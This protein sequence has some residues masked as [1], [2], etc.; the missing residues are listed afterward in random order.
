MY[1]WTFF[2]LM[3]SNASLRVATMMLVALV[4]LYA[5]D[6]GLSP[7]QVGLTSTLYFA[8]AALC[9]PL[10][11]WLVDTKGRWLIMLLG[12]VLFTLATG[13]YLLSLPVW[14]F[15][16]L[17]ALQGAGFSLNGTA[18]GTL[19]TDIIPEKKLAEGLGIL[20]LEQTAVTI[21]A[22]GLALTL[23]E[24]A[25]YETAFGVALAFCLMNFLLR[26]PL[27]KP[28]KEVE[29]RRRAS[30]SS[31]TH[32]GILQLVE[33]DAW[34]P[35]TVML[36]FMFGTTCVNT[37]LAAYGLQQGL[38]NVGLFFV[39]SGIA[40]A[41]SRLL[42][43]WLRR[44]MSLTMIVCFGVLFSTASMALIYFAASMPMLIVSGACFG[45]GAGVVSPAMNSISV[46]SAKPE[47]R[48]KASAT[49]FFALDVSTAAGA[50]ILGLV[51]SAA[52]MRDVFAVSGVMVLSSLL[53]ILWLHR[54][55]RLPRKGI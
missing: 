7:V 13:L 31:A 6:L 46:L 38:G 39:A 18:V 51:A 26:I 29:I 45:F 47:A 23:R 17:R 55:Q 8:T 9:R 40:L 48:G 52:S 19:A 41:V 30:M 25:G 42:M 22:P 5:F 34:R 49:Y 36:C 11:G 35:A 28:A 2:A 16:A 21:F 33:K 3:L 24:I 53:L 37:F 32:R 27:A 1:N 12:V 54:T 14:L 44:R 15:L 43:G 20:S 4:P 50:W 10:A